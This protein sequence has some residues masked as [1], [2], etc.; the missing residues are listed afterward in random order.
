[1]A[2]LLQFTDLHWFADPLGDYRGMV[3]RRSFAAV[4]AAARAAHPEPAALLLSGDLVDDGAPAG[5]T[6]LAEALAPF[7]VPAL[8]IPGNHDAPTALAALSGRPQLR[9]GGQHRVGRWQVCLLN[10]FVP[11]D[12]RGRIAPAQLATLD[13]ALAREPD[14]PA[15]VVLH[16]HALPVGSRWLDGVALQE[17][18]RLFEVLD[19]HARVQAVVCGHVHQ[20]Y[21]GARRGVRYLATPSTCVQFLAH[22][23]DFATDP[24]LDPGY[25]WLELGDDGTLTT[26][27]VRVR[28]VA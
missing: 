12:A 9:V 22:N 11:D 24:A 6:A 5:Y 10:T 20:E 7:A 25:R 13:K 18:E 8:C 21:D 28:V 19:R 27:V 16:H 14:R 15:L 3:T 4:A 23:D 26:G 17:P 2:L 1:M